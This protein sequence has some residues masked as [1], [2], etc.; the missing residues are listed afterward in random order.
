MNYCVRIT[1]PGIDHQVLISSVEDLEA[2]EK[3]IEKMKRH[4][5]SQANP[6]GDK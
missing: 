3:I 4:L 2:L 1:G 6:E 5:A